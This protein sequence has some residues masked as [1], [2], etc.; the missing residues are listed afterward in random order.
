LFGMV[1]SIG[2]LEACFGSEFQGPVALAVAKSG[3]WL[4]VACQDARQVAVVSVPDGR[5]V[6]RLEMPAPPTG[7]AL[8]SDG[9]RLIVT[10]AA[11]E[12]PVV[13][14]DS[15]TGA[16]V[17]KFRAGHTA[18]SPVLSPDD[19][20]LLVCNRFDNDVSVIELATGR[21]VRRISV[22]REP[23]AADLTPDGRTLLVANHLANMRT[24]VPITGEV[25]PIVSAVQWKTGRVSAIP[26]PNGSHSLRGLCVSPDGRHAFVTHL[27]GN[28]QEMPFR[29]DMGWINTNVVSI[30]DIT[31]EEVTA[32]I[33][34]D[35]LDRGAANPWGITCTPD[36]RF[37]C[38]ALAGTHELAVIKRRDLLS[39]EARRTMSPMMGVWPIY[40]SLGATLWRRI[41]LPGK[42]PRGLAATGSTVFVSDYF[43]DEVVAVSVSASPVRRETES[44]Y[45]DATSD[46]QG[47]GDGRE[48]EPEESSRGAT[49]LAAFQPSGRDP[50]ETI[51]TL[52][53][54]PRPKLTPQRRGELLFNDATICYQR[55]QS[56]ASC[57]PDA[58][59]DSLNWD[60]LN[61]GAGNPKNTKSLLLAHATPPSMATGVRPTA[62]H[63]VRSGLV[64]ILFVERPDEEAAAIDAYLK[65]LQPVVSPHRVK[66][67]LSPAA[68]RGRRLFFSPRIGCAR[69]H[70]PPL[71]TDR[72]R[73]NVGT[74]APS[75][76][77]LSF[78]TPTLIEVWR[79][80]PYL[81]DGRYT[82]IPQLLREGRHGLQGPRSRNL[83]DQEIRDLAEFVLSL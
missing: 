14:I 22:E 24:N 83:T 66:G 19:R 18:M 45:G 55:W 82:T 65:S 23:I 20:F 31:L 7:L 60:L 49:R 8:T 6:R 71:Y 33:G 69:C 79:T 67:E 56:C 78:D 28:F 58:R 52:A 43:S 72:K 4:Y 41:P 40:L 29:V 27:Q 21:T 36:G 1:A 30:I 53:L 25:T 64:H 16:R 75:D 35:D 39:D 80:A 15:S 5:V 76:S 32:T 13:V 26:L 42:G 73:H 51:R 70:P 2:V 44:L 9:E 17:A 48:Q 34:L 68:Q 12:S 46:Q 37:V 77:H 47:D 74:A 63:A 11:P 62:E 81:H 57:H 38:V 61:D 59:T 54:G 10:C 50:V 3:R